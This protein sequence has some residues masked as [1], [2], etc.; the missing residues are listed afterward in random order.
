MWKMT[1]IKI[2]VS[3]YILCQIERKAEIHSTENFYDYLKQN[4][5]SYY[6]FL[7]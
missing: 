4:T 2:T 5:G 1:L 7:N 3:T 6:D